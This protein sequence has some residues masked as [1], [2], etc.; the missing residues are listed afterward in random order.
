M[1]NFIIQD[2]EFITITQFLKVEGYIQSGGEARLF[3]ATN[4]PTLNN[5]EIFEK[6]KK[7]RPGDILHV[8]DEVYT[9][10]YD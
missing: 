6:K 5:E 8:L 3:F 10:S 7:M 2:A 4:K 9:F 1:K